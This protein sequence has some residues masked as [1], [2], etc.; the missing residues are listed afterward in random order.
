VRVSVRALA[1]KSSSERRLPVEQPIFIFMVRKARRSRGTEEEVSGLGEVSPKEVCEQLSSCP[2]TVE[3]V[4]VRTSDLT[5]G[6]VVR[7]VVKSLY[8]D[9]ALP[10]GPLVQWFLYMLLGV[11]FNHRQIRDLI[12]A[13]PGVYA[14]PPN[15]KKLNFQA[16]LEDLP[17]GFKGFVSDEDVAKEITEELWQEAAYCLSE[18]GWPKAEDASHK[19]FVVASWLQDVSP[20]FRALSFGRV[21]GVVRFGLQSECLLGHRGGVLVPYAHSE[22]CERRV[23]ACTGLP[24]HVQEGESYVKTW[25]EL[26]DCLRKLLQES[27]DEV[28]GGGQP[29]LEVSKLKLMF[30]T[31]FETELSETVFGHECLS[32][33]LGD[34]RIGDEFILDTQDH[35]YMLRFRGPSDPEACEAS[36]AA[37]I[38]AKVGPPPGLTPELVGPP[39]GLAPDGITPEKVARRPPTPISLSLATALPQ[40]KAA[41]AK[42]VV[43]VS[44]DPVTKKLWATI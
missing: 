43:P 37:E 40:E 15:S 8:Q 41:T 6:A 17:P 30:R 39:P 27:K 23:N 20:T 19:F 13:T 36:N 24:T 7:W 29:M 16:V 31:R 28:P 18:G 34:S 25:L 32:K 10:R 4:P 14:D 21:L 1:H 9:E 38:I 42:A 11:K 26:Q 5:A 12:E 2:A 35:R 33:L 22:E 3:E 44:V